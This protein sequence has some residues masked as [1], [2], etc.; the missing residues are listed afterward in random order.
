MTLA[1]LK[2]IDFHLTNFVYRGCNYNIS[3][4]YKFMT[5]ENITK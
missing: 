3:T 1:E 5:A 2:L 4:I